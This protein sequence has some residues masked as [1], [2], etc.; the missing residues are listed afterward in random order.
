[1]SDVD[2]ATKVGSVVERLKGSAKQVAGNVNG[3]RD[4]THEGELHKEKAETAVE[5]AKAEA[6]AER[7]QAKAQVVTREKE[8]EA[9]RER[10]Q[11]ETAAEQ[12]EQQAE[13]ARAR[14][15]QHIAAEA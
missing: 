11:A 15:E 13:L 4:L 8:I 14:A 12:R 2:P 7:E 6:E 1:M 10:L 9:E 5:A 3:N